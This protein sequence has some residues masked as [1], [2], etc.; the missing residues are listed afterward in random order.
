MSE[1]LIMRHGPT[2]WN[3]RKLIQGSTDIPLSAE[4]RA[5]VSSWRIPPRFKD[6]HCQCS[7]LKR[8][9]ETARI[10]GLEPEP[11]AAIRETSWGQWEGKSL[12]GL[13]DEL[14]SAMAENEARGLDFQPP[15]GESP[16]D[17]QDR[18]RPW[19]R[20]LDKATVAVAHKGVIRALY[21]IASGWDMRD[22]P[23]TKMREPAAHLFKVDETGHPFI[24]QMNIMLKEAN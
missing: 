13:R 9:L 15:D 5:E 8:A 19:L 21:G 20:T 16:R 6:Y 7:P 10:L 23:Q 11:V 2:D 17:V 4:G 22:K 18:L 24:E 3:A 14:G 12:A 1:L